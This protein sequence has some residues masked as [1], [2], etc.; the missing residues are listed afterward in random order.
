M[1]QARE[2]DRRQ[3]AVLAQRSLAGSGPTAVRGIQAKRFD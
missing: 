3:Q 1:G 2:V